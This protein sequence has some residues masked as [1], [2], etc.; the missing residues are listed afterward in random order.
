MTRRK[1]PVK[2]PKARRGAKIDISS[3]SVDTGY[4]RLL[5]PSEVS[6]TIPSWILEQQSPTHTE[7]ETAIWFSEVIRYQNCTPRGIRARERQQIQ[8]LPSW[9]LTLHEWPIGHIERVNKV[10]RKM[11]EPSVGSTFHVLFREISRIQRDRNEEDPW[12][13]HTH[14]RIRTEYG[15]YTVD[16][17]RTATMR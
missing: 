2:K 3:H 12:V 4:E 14:T 16:E 8:P 1:F 13:H 5:T 10:C 17:L 15:N 6:Q 11:E 7:W 9:T